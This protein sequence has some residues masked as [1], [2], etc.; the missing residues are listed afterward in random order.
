MEW[1]AISFSRGS[2]WPGVRDGELVF[3]V[4]VRE[5]EKVLELLVVCGGWLHSSVKVLD[6]ELHT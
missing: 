1:V 6:T 4:S 2:L 5:D 3:P